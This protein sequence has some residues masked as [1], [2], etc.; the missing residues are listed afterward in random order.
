[1]KQLLTPD[2]VEGGDPISP[3]P[4]P[5]VIPTP[6]PAPPPAAT[7]VLTGTKSERELQLEA[8]LVNLKREKKLREI[9]AA[10]L[11]DENHRLKFVT[12]ETPPA[13]P[14]DTA[15]KYRPI[16]RSE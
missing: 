4:S 1:M 5:E 2:A 14:A 8:E 3:V 13:A 12:K 10:E 6:Q 7:A 15:W 16:K 11:F 9:E